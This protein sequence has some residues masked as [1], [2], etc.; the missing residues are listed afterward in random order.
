[1]KFRKPLRTATSEET[2]ALTTRRQDIC[3]EMMEDYQLSTERI[4]KLKTEMPKNFDLHA[5]EK[6]AMELFEHFSKNGY[7][8]PSV[9][10]LIGKTSLVLFFLSLAIVTMRTL[11]SWSTSSYII[12][13]IS[14]GLFWHQCGYMMHDSEHHNLAGNERCNDIMGWLFGTV[15]LGVN[16][17]WWREEH[18]EHHAFLNTFDDKEGYKDPQVRFCCWYARLHYLLL[19]KSHTKLF[20]LPLLNHYFR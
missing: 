15:F 9:L 19:F 11:P 1:M 6:D 8:K 10:W 3:Q 12:P 16:G 4:T 17:A 14:L 13:G 2:E 18:R 5:F 7:F 20:F